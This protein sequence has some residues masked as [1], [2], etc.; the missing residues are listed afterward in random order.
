MRRRQVLKQFLDG[1]SDSAA[2]PQDECGRGLAPDVDGSVTDAFT[3]TPSS[4]A[5]PLPHLDQR[6]MWGLFF[7]LTLQATLGFAHH[8][9]AIAQR[10]PCARD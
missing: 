7:S 3:D 1:W 10:D 6:R 8:V 9:L 4:G 2:S 5:S